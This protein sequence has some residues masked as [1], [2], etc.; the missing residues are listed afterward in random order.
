MSQISSLNRPSLYL[1]LKMIPIKIPLSLVILFVSFACQNNKKS[2]VKDL[3]EID[4]EI[5]KQKIIV[6]V[7]INNKTYK[8]CLDTGSMTSISEKLKNKLSPEVVDQWNIFDGNNKNQMIESYLIN[9]LNLGNIHFDN[10]EAISYKESDVF[11]CFAF[12]GYIGSDLLLDFI[13]QID[14]NAKKIRMTKKINSILLDASSRGE[15]MVIINGHTPYI[16]IRFGEKASSFKDF[17]MVDTGMKGIYDLSM[18]NYNR[19]LKNKR[20]NLLSKSEGSSTIGA[21]GLSDV[22]EQLL[23]HYPSISIGDFTLKN[24]INKTTQSLNSRIGAGLL[25]YGVMT[26][27]FINEKFYFD[28]YEEEIKLDQH[29][30]LF[31]ATFKDK[32][33]VVGIV[34]DEALKN[35]IKFGDQILEV[36][37]KDITKIDFCELVLSSSILDK[38]TNLKIKFKR[39]KDSVFTLNLKKEK[40]LFNDL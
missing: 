21:F 24:Y 18:D 14:L 20:I 39:D 13:I 4:F 27:D 1:T 40:L 11:K 38:G 36:N 23:F 33:I 30:P 5:L 12:D 16:W 37:D 19:L 17:V 25:K 15:E 22:S 34:W 9:D 35:K 7:E 29:K 2:D 26:F 32:K 6:P 3:I 31:Q 8:F 10:V 28:S